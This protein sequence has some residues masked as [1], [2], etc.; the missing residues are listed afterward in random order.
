MKGWY[1]EWQKKDA[2]DIK[3]EATRDIGF[4]LDQV[5]ARAK[6]AT[7]NIAK[8]DYFAAGDAAAWINF[9]ALPHVYPDAEFLQ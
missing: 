4:G 7:D 3:K 8:K 9:I 6:Q 5:Q 1:D 2:D